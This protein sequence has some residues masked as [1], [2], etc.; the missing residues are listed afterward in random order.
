MTG[1]SEICDTTFRGTV[2]ITKALLPLLEKE[3]SDE[4]R[5]QIIF[6]ASDWALSGSHGPSVFSAAKAAVRVFS[7]TL[8]YEVLDAGIKP[9]VI[10][11]GDI[12]SFDLDW[13]EPKWDIDDLPAVIRAE[14]GRSRILLAKLV[15]L[16]ISIAT[17]GEMML[18]DEVHISPEDPAYSY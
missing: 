13:K 9:T 12:A 15:N 11:A 7:H 4:E 2:F 18:I 1:F 6:M 3:K 10:T 8:K 16:V 14:L 5:S 17:A